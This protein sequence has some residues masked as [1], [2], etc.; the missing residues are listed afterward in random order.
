MNNHWLTIEHVGE[1]VVLKK[2]SQEAEGTIV[3]PGNVTRIERFA[4]CRCKKVM[5]VCLPKLIPGIRE[6]SFIGSGIKTL[7]INGVEFEQSEPQGNEYYKEKHRDICKKYF[8]ENGELNSNIDIA[9]SEIYKNFLSFKEHIISI[10]HNQT[11]NIESAFYYLEGFLYE[12]YSELSGANK[13]IAK[14]FL[15]HFSKCYMAEAAYAHNI[16][17]GNIK[18]ESEEQGLNIAKQRLASAVYNG[19]SLLKLRN[20]ACLADLLLNHMP[21]LSP[22]ER[23]IK[24]AQA[25]LKSW[26]FYEGRVTSMSSMTL[27]LNGFGLNQSN[28]TTSIQDMCKEIG[29]D[30]KDIVGDG[31][32]DL[33]VLNK[34]RRWNIANELCKSLVNEEDL[35]MT[36]FIESLIEYFVSI[37]SRKNQR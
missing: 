35:Q 21:E 22:R 12:H 19:A 15:E 25:L 9:F 3:V 23:K 8:P 10:L 11:Y 32:K 37:E 2:C 28:G 4:F 24:A 5:S 20:I 1:E 36:P 27:P 13:T 26:D 16:L 7:V 14:P 30:V 34:C 17:E 29:I 18:L 6:D 31:N 33:E